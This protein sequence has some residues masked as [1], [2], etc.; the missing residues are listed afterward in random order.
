MFKLDLIFILVW[1]ATH[2]LSFP[3]FCHGISG[4]GRPNRW[5]NGPGGANCCIPY[6]GRM[7]FDNFLFLAF[8]F[9]T[10]AMGFYHMVHLYI[11]HIWDVMEFS[12]ICSIMLSLRRSIFLWRYVAIFSSW[13]PDAVSWQLFIWREVLFLPS[14]WRPWSASGACW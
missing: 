3:T 14:G 2:C 1:S 9:G 10:F 5:S 7:L 6:E 8:R 11:F 13:I 4:R 12:C